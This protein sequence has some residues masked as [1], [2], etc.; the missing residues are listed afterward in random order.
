MSFLIF[1]TAV[2][3]EEEE[4]EDLLG[5]VHSYVDFIL[6]SDDGSTDRTVELSRDLADDIIEGPHLGSCEEVRIRGFNEIHTINKDIWVLILDADERIPQEHLAQM[7]EWLES[8]EAKLYDH[9]YFSQDEYIDGRLER[10]FAKIKLARS[11]DL[12]LPAGIHQD[13]SASGE[14]INKGWKVIHRKTSDKQ[15]MRELEYLWAYEK[16]IQEG[17]MTRQRADEVSSWHYF[18]KKLPEGEKVV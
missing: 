16:Q 9:V 11:T 14:G 4:I 6:V 15:K 3:N 10:S 18:I 1:L 8:P 12:H 5:S 17:K 13:V 2:Y 7:S